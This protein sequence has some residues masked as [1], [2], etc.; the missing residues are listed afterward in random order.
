[1][2][3]AFRPHVNKATL[4][5]ATLAASLLFAEFVVFR[6]ILVPSDQVRHTSANGVLRYAPR[7]TAHLRHPD[8]RTSRVS[9]NDH[10]WNSSKRRYRRSPP[11]GRIR[12][13]VIG[14][15]FVHGAIVDPEHGFPEVLEQD[16]NNRSTMPVDVIRF[17]MEGAPLSQYLHMLRQEVLHYRPDVVLVQLTHDDFGPSIGTQPYRKRSRFLTM[18]RN[19]DGTVTELPP[20]QTSPSLI[21]VLRNSAALRYVHEKISAYRRT[22]V[23]NADPV[24]VH[25]KGVKA[26]LM[27]PAT[28]LAAVSETDAIAFFTLHI[29]EKM[30][31]LSEQHGFKLVF[32]MDGV[33]EAIYAQKNAS[34]YLVGTLNRIAAN[35]AANIGAPFIDLQGPFAKHYNKTKQRLEFSHN[36]HWNRMGHKIAGK[37]IADHFLRNPDLLRKRTAQSAYRSATSTAQ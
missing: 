18:R 23:L 5:G 13:A 19:N 1:M 32:A 8:G 31:A 26:K 14:D 9:I 17:G 20:G 27:A 29:M 22:K 10:G 24:R 6:Y 37:H 11:P 35:T 15:S 2:F 25:V 36:W 7:T 30:Q 21:A 3:G 34:Q 28:D 12:I 4:L 16:L 33:R